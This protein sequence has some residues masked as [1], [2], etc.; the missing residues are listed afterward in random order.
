MA[1]PTRVDFIAVEFDTEFDPNSSGSPLGEKETLF[2][3]VPG[4]ALGNVGRTLYGV[5]PDDQRFLA[6][7]LQG[8]AGDEA[9]VSELI[10]VQNWFEELKER[11]PN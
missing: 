2:P 5:T 11:V 7:R 10:L 1:P 8:S 6:A 3:L 9:F 4:E